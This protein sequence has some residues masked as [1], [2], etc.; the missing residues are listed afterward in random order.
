M[1]LPFC[2]S[3]INFADRTESKWAVRR[4]GVRNRVIAEI[5]AFG[6]EGKGKSER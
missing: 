6:T 3:A 5:E 2:H 1:C 4:S